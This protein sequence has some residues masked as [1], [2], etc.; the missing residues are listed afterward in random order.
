[1]DETTILLL[2][3]IPYFIDLFSGIFCLRFLIELSDLDEEREN[4][5]NK[6]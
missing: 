5:K 6:K 4:F 1:M 2:F 3:S